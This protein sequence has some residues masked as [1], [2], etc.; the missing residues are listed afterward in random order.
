M[1]EWAIG[2]SSHRYGKYILHR[3][4]IY[5]QEQEEWRLQT[6]ARFYFLGGVTLLFWLS[7]S[8][9]QP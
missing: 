6:S 8:W 9:M 1:D 3:E 2:Q 4:D 5:G 7:W